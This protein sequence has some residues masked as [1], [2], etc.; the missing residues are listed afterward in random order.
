MRAMGRVPEQK[1]GTKPRMRISWVSWFVLVVLAGIV[2]AVVLPSY[3]DYIHRSQMSEAVA[4]LGAAKTP[5][6]E[7]LADRKKWPESAGQVLGSTSGRYTQSVVI[8]KGA[9]GTGAV[10]L[11][12]TLR[13]E[14]VDRRVAGKSVRIFSTDGGK[15]WNCRAGTAAE[16]ALPPACRAD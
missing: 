1:D 4:L 14:G 2:G 11:T 13:A 12:A 7:Y 16:S 10:E 3:G 6:S 5:F 8:T 9:G 15:T